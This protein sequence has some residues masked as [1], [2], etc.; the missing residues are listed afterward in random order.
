MTFDTAK[1][2]AK[3]ASPKLKKKKSVGK[4]IVTD[5]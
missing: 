5:W 3:E 1:L 4:N 2:E